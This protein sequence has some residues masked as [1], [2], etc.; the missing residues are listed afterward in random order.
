M[1]IERAGVTILPGARFQYDRAFFRV[2]LGREDMGEAL[3]AIEPY[4][5]DAANG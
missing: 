1:L 3:E 2:G 5:A 4:L